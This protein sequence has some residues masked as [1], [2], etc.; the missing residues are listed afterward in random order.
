[1]LGDAVISSEIFCQD[2]YNA[3]LSHKLEPFRKGSAARNT[4]V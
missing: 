4:K 1:M 3:E 2:S